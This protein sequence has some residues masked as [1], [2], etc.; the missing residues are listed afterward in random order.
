MRRE[1]EDILVLLPYPQL[2][3]IRK[4]IPIPRG[5]ILKVNVIVQIEFELNHYNVVVQYGSHYVT[6]SRAHYKH[7]VSN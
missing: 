1:K 4:F 3:K 6:G 2:G 5:I 7:Q